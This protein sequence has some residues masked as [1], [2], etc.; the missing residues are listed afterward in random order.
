MEYKDRIS[1]DDRQVVYGE[2]MHGPKVRIAIKERERVR[3]CK[4]SARTRAQNEILKATETQPN[5]GQK[6]SGKQCGK[7]AKHK[8]DGGEEH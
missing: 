8:V 4:K 2:V 7:K 6:T 1:D 5:N 3:I